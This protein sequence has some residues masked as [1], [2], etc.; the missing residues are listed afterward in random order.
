[1]NKILRQHNVIASIVIVTTIIAMTGILSLFSTPQAKAAWYNDSWNFRQKIIIDHTKVPNTDQIDFPVLVKI[2]DA[3]NQVFTQAKD[4]GSDIRFTGSNQTTDLNFEIESFSKSTHELL[5]WVK[6]PTLSH[7]NNN[8]IYL[9]YGNSIASAPSAVFKQAVWSNGYVGVWHMG[10]ASW[11]GVSGEAKDALGQ[12]N[13]TASAGLS[14]ST[15]KIGRDENLTANGQYLEVANPVGMTLTEANWQMRINPTDLSVARVLIGRWPVGDNAGQ[16]AMQVNTDGSITVDLPWV[17]GAVVSA[18]AGTVTAGSWQRYVLQ[19]TAAGAWKIY[20][21]NLVVGSSN[22]TTAWVNSGPF[23]IGARCH[24]TTQSFVGGMDEVSVGN[25]ARSADWI[26][27]EYANQNSPETFITTSSQVSKTTASY[28]TTPAGWYDYTWSRRQPI[29]INHTKVPNTDQTDFPVLV[30]ITDVSNEIWARAQSDGDDILFTDTSDN[31]LAHEIEKYDPVTHELYAWVKIPA[32]SHSTD[33]TIY[34]Y[35]GNATTVSQQSKTAV[36]SNGYAGV[37]HLGDTGSSSAADSTLNGKNGTQSGGVIFGATGEIGKGVQ[38]VGGGKISLSAGNLLFGSKPFTVSTWIN[39]S[40][41]P[42]YGPNM[43]YLMTDQDSNYGLAFNFAS[44]GNYNYTNMIPVSGHGWKALRNNSFAIS[45]GNWYQVVFTYNGA[46]TTTAGNYALYINGTQRSLTSSYENG[47]ASASNSTLGFNP[48][49]NDSL[50]Y[51]DEMRISNTA[52][53]SADWVATEYNNQNDPTGFESVQAAQSADTSAPANPT[54]I[55]ALYSVGGAPILNN[56]GS[57]ATPYYSW[58]QPEAAGGATDQTGTFYSGVDGYYSYFGTSCGAGGADPT[59]TPGILSDTGSG[60]HY[61]VDTS[62]SVPQIPTN[63]DSY[64]LRLKTRDAAGNISATTEVAT[65]NFDSVSPNQPTFVAVS[66]AGYSL[67]DSFDFSWP[68]ATDVAGPASSG[69]QGYQYKRGGTSGDDWSAIQS[70]RTATG[71]HKYQ[72]GQN[73]FQVRTVDNVGNVSAEAQTNYYYSANPPSKPLSLTASPSLSDSN[74][75]SFSWSEPADH[76][77]PISDYGYSINAS[78]TANNITWLGSNGTSLPQ[79]HYATIQGENTLYLVA[80]DDTGAFALSSNSVASVSFNCTTPAPVAPAGV[81]ISDSSDRVLN[82]WA[83]T[84]K[85]SAGVGQDSSTFSHYL[86]EKSTD[87]LSFATLATTASTAYIDATGLTNTSTYYYRIRAVDNAGSISAAQGSVS[88]MPTGKFTE[89]PTIVTEPTY[90]VKATSAVIS[91][92]VNRPSSSAVR[93]GKSQSDL[94]RSQIDPTARTEQSISLVGLEPNTTYYYQVQ[95]LDAQKDYSS[96]S[97]YS[98]THQ[99]TTLSAPTLSNVSVSNITLNSADVTWQ[100]SSASNT[101]VYYGGSIAYGSILPENDLSMTTEHSIKLTNLAD[102]TKYHF[103]IQGNDI[104]NNSLSS[105]D[106]TFETLP[107]PKIS[108]IDYQPDFSGP[109]PLV[110]ISWLTNVPTSS[111][112]EYSP[113][114]S[115]DSLS[116]E[117]SQ[118]ALVLQHKVTLSNLKD[119]TDYKFQIK[120]VDQFGNGASSDIQIMKTG[121][122]SRPPKI[123]NIIIESSN[124]GNRS[125]GAQLVISWETDEDSASQVEYG[126]GLES[127]TG[128]KKSTGDQGLTRKHLVIISGLTPSSPYH[129]RVVSEDNAGNTATSDNLITTTGSVQQGTFTTILNTL[130]SLFGWVG[131]LMN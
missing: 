115:A 112:V 116:F 59:L 44:D 127:N 43:F 40:T 17:K 96:E 114:D 51:Y 8:I 130:N 104:D 121:Q 38:F 29:V 73:L 109:A 70:G 83:L 31:K 62:I 50:A 111:S 93:F 131:K 123:S 48:A 102:T 11:G 35:Y 1:M 74:N 32:L 88:K 129:L 16:I 36:W 103:K 106:Y 5:A 63:Q 19:R 101:K 69:F 125:D 39:P 89:P 60:L 117:E 79:D 27:T 7:L 30:K 10:E 23:R 26:A 120:G 61:S 4:D 76:L 113:K 86:V 54:H 41:L 47:S 57:D 24:T 67:T 107:Q 75:F 87:G 110:V 71:I 34:L 42:S 49:G 94:S 53:R 6:I 65:Y 9:Y 108:Q 14:T 25:I 56:A 12:N 78:P 98:L 95:S 90:S 119:S 72:D 20:K 80:K 45:A 92:V 128:V 100:S 68:A 85:W 91:W 126:P 81:A 33:T 46:G 55:T 15:G 82:L 13:A 58:P 77:T 52:I 84:I 99:F 18:P 28:L 3:A 22:D 97:A 118:S 124:V 66:P 2:S 105:D 122:D 37:W 21:N 64:C